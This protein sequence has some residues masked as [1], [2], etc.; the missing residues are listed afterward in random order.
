MPNATALTIRSSR[1]QC[2]AFGL[3][4]RRLAQTLAL[5]LYLV[6]FASHCPANFTR[7]GF[8][9]AAR[10]QFLC[11]VLSRPLIV[12][13]QRLSL[14]CFQ[15]ERTG[16]G[17]YAASARPAQAGDYLLVATGCLRL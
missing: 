17:D 3:P 7:S 5:P 12:K 11:A 1:T 9:N 14:L 10:H 15:P 13:R 4:L 16:A 2:Q 8:G 6:E